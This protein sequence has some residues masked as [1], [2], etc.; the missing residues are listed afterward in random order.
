[1]DFG[2]SQEDREFRDQVRSFI[3]QEWTAPPE[4][5]SAEEADAVVRAYDKR[6]AAHGWLT[7]AWPEEYGGRGASHVQQMI[8]REEASLAGA[9]MDV[10]GTGMVGPCVMVHGTEDQKQQFLPPI[11]KAETVWAQGYSE[12]GSGSDLASLQTRAGARWR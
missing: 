7:M 9:P 2:F 4:E 8:Y 1:M 11:A 12:P 3:A 6:L 5:A 10:Q